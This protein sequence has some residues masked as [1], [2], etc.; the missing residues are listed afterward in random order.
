MRKLKRSVARANM[1]RAGITKINSRS[2]KARLKYI[3]SDGS[4]FSNHWRDYI[5]G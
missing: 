2:K 1:E 4:Y 5:G 3:F